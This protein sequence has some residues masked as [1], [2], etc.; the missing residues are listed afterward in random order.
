MRSPKRC[1]QAIPAKS[2]TKIQN[3]K[4]LYGILIAG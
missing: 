4:D 2:P 1:P 3:V